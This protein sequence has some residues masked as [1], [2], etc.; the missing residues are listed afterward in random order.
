VQPLAIDEARGLTAAQ[1]DAIA[2]LERRVVAHD[3]GRLKL[4]WGV[5]MER[6]AG[7]VND[8]FVWENG[9]LVGFCGIY[10]FGGEPELAGAVEPTQRRRGIGSSLLARAL[11]RV[12]QRGQAGVLLVTPTATEAGRRFA[13]AKG[14]TL[15][16]SEHHL[17]LD[18][19]PAG[20]P[21]PRASTAGLRI[22]P[23]RDDDADRN[24]I[25]PILEAAFG[26][27]ATFAAQTGPSDLALV[28]ERGDDVVGAL[29]LDL[30][31]ESAGIYGLAVRPDLR[32]QGIGRAV[33]YEVCL[34]ARRRGALR[35][36]LE[37]ETDN[38]H[39]LGLYT[40]VGFERRTTEDYF[41][42][43]TPPA[44]RSSGGS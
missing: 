37:V 21:E 25:V 14:A 20:P 19:R 30:G 10:H 3:G 8:L 5:L 23:A 43:S 31:G 41:S 12:A 26:E 6:P 39:A 27:G 24:A 28:V 4:A 15:H 44:T 36:T 32:G 22:R 34:E 33:L 18:G 9:A 17:E 11:E 7:E 2:D 1:L 13:L 35:V 42:L 40:S 16:H 38:D 29:R